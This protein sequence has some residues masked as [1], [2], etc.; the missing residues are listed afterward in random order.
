MADM[1]V[2]L[3]D[4]PSLAPAIDRAAPHGVSLRRPQAWEKALL[5]AWVRDTFSPGWALEC[6][7]AFTRQPA[8]CFIAVADA[9]VVGFA[10][11]DCTRANFFGPTGVAP[12]ARGQG[13]GSALLLACLHAMRD[14]G[15]AYAI[16]GGVGPAEFYAKAVDAQPIAG[17]TPGIYDLSL[18]T[19]TSRTAPAG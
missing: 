3:Y 9:A 19:R 12:A 10:C 8:A 7:A 15:Y 4:L 16:I 5:I 6:E 2:R 1:L 13:V 18:V 14:A 11:H 17:S